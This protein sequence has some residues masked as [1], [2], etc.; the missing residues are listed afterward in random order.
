MSKIFN[1]LESLGMTTNKTSELFAN[2]TRDMDNLKVY[3]DS[4]S[5]VIYIDNFFI[6]DDT[7]SEGAYREKQATSSGASLED[8]ADCKRRINDFSKYYHNKVICDFG[9]G[10]GTFLLESLKHTK[11]SF[12]VE[13]QKN[14]AKELNKKDIKCFNSISDVHEDIDSCF[15]FHVLEHLEDPISHLETI[16][17]RLS[18]KGRVIIEVPHARDFL[19]KKLKIDE[20]IKFTLWSQHLILHTRES[21]TAVL[22][23]AGFKNIEI[24]GVQRF[25]IANHMQWMKDRIPGGHRGELQSIETSELRSAYQESLNKIDATDTLIAIAER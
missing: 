16:R 7:Y 10:E 1:L 25:S 3:K 13:L 6:G 18:D 20:F 2:S 23:D 11:K 15:L 4:V 24:H 8:K 14:Y 5:D 9:C 17:S 12:G 21:L 22:K 19:I